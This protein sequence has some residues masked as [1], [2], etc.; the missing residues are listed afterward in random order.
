MNQNE[1]LDNRTKVI[2]EVIREKC[3]GCE[4]CVLICPQG[5]LHLDESTFNTN[6]FHA[7]S[8]VYKGMKGHCNA[9]GLCYM[10]CPDYAVVTIKK[11][12]DKEKS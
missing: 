2:V 9:C 4:L 1:V 6:G 5:C 12:K 7:A 11:L 3:K 8:Y 10:V